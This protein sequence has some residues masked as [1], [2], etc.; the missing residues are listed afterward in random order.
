MKELIRFNVNE[1]VREIYIEPHKTLL[2][3]LRQELNLTGAKYGCG[4]GECGSCTVLIDGEAIL[5]CFKLANRA[6]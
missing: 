3:V 2:E 5:S 1:K 6:K 4:K